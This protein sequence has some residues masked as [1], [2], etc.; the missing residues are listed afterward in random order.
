MD[1]NKERVIILELVPTSISPD[2][3]EIVQLSALKLNGMKL[4]DRFD[5]RLNEAK[6]PYKSFLDLFSYDK[7]SF[8]YMDS[9]KEI[10]DDFINWIEDV[11][12]LIIDN[13]YTRNYLSSINNKKESIFDYLNIDNNDDVID[14]LISKYHIEPTNYVVDILYEALMQEIL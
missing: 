10:L 12:L 9:T 2:N 8:R 7:E 4:E 14:R 1:L 6:I 3:G 13:S 5:Y 11:P